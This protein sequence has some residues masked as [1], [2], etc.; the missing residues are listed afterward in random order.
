MDFRV[1]QSWGICGCEQCLPHDASH[2]PLHGAAPTDPPSHPPSLPR[3][4]PQRRRRLARAAPMTDNG[5]TKA[6]RGPSF[7]AAED[8]ALARAWIRITESVAD[9]Y[10]DLFGERVAAVYKTQP[11]A[12]IQRT[13]HSL[14]SR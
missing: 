3:C 4:Y 11:E 13:C 12:V 7:S 6:I 10:H 8:L 14:R 5:S 9:M 2:V 1:A